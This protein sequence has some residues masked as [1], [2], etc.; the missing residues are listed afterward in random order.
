MGEAFIT[1]R[2]GGTPYAVIGVTYPSGSVCTCTSGTLTLTA[3]DTSGKALFVIP[4]AGTWTVKAVKGSQS[5]SVAVKITTEGQVET[6][7]L[8]YELILFDGTNGGDNTAVTGGW[9][10]TTGDGDNGNEVSAE[11]IYICNGGGEDV[12]SYYGGT[13]SATTKNKIDMNNYTICRVTVTSASEDSK[14]IVGAASL[15]ISKAGTYDLDISAISNST[16][17]QLSVTRPYGTWNGYKMKTT[18]ITLL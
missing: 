10:L 17:V 2:G 4:S 8:T 14:I 11:S 13:S 12:G 7:T 3:K 5:K 16:T 18:N 9:T 15:T 6:V 1:R